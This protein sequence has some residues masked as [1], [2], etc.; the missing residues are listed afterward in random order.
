[1]PWH[2]TGALGAADTRRMRA[3]LAAN[4]RLAEDFAAIRREQAAVVKLAAPDGAPSLRPLIA[5]FAAIDA[6]LARP[7]KVVAFEIAGTT[8]YSVA[9]NPG[10]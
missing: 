1:M 9:K 7:A 10:R 2:A 8:R 4:D 5:L 3:A 6:D